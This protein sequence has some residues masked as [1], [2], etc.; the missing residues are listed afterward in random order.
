MRETQIAFQARPLE[1]SSERSQISLEDVVAFLRRYHRLILLVFGFCV[2]ATYVTLSLLTEQYDTTATV[3]VKMGREN[4]DPPS[5]ARNSVFSTGVRHE[6]VMSEIELIKSPLLLQ[7]VVDE[8]GP[9]AFKDHRV[10][11]PGLIGKA[12]YYTKLV[13]RFGKQ[14]Y[15]NLLYALSLKRRLDDRDGAV[16][17]LVGDLS[18]T[19]QKDTDVFQVS[20]R[21]ADPT[22]SKRILDQLLHDYLLLHTEI[23][24]GHGVEEFMNSESTK[25]ESN[26]VAAEEAEDKWKAA[27]DL[28]SVKDQRPLYLQT[29]RDLANEH[30]QTMRD[31]QTATRQLESLKELI[32][33]T[34]ENMKQSQQD[35][36]SPVINSYRQ[37]LT[38][39]QAERAELLSKYKEGSTVI[40]NKNEEIDR[41]KGL[42]GGERD[43]ETAAVTITANP[44][45]QDLEKKLHETEIAI[46][47]LEAR[48]TAQVGQLR[49]L[50]GKLS[51]FDT[52]DSH[53][54]DLQRNRELLEA[55]YVSVAKR[56]EDTELSG[57]LDSSRI[58]NVAIVAP[59][60]T[61]P[62]P[63]YPR[64]MLL[65]YVSMGVGLV[66][67]IALALLLNYLDDE[68]HSVS[69]VQNILGAPCFGSLPAGAGAS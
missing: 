52:A 64:K 42:I 44:V 38:V 46:S 20:L 62:E 21:M 3:I 41:L 4:L 17:E 35:V 8:I 69:D 15:K 39:L 50:Q 9:E 60:W 56:K 25:L 13:L 58:S 33:S 1:A 63:A 47:G 40:V 22:L 49:D 67:G 29:I 34:P 5:T 10:P 24:R 31:I 7:Q 48:S 26:L 61:D 54:R 45:R 53:L 59:P 12:K 6:D 55:Q 28:S 32:R 16:V 19:W 14:Q 68:V 51:A 66:L 65:M 2:L 57:A 11:P 18:M 27:H 30:D 37:R 23:R 36:T 43:T